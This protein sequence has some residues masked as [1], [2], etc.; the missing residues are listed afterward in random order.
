MGGPGTRALT[1][2]GPELGTQLLVGR[3]LP[4]MLLRAASLC[5][6]ICQPFWQ[7]KIMITTP[8]ACSPPSA[9]GSWVSCRGAWPGPCA[10]AAGGPRPEMA[11]SPQMCRAGSAC[12][13][14]E[15]R[16]AIEPAFMH[17][18]QELRFPH[19]KV[20]WGPTVPRACVGPGI[21]HNVIAAPGAVLLWEWQGPGQVLAGPG[22]HGVHRSD[23]GAL[24][25]QHRSLSWAFPCPQRGWAHCSNCLHSVHP[26]PQR[27]KASVKLALPKPVNLPSL[28]KVRGVPSVSALAAHGWERVA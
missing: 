20:Y 28:K 2:P 24:R 9:R 13:G 12:W 3:R 4:C 27:A 5:R 11:R 26:L 6:A 18:D 25:G 23:Q 1:Q 16:T 21:A 19:Q 17:P 10:R 15:I 22:R 7:C 8:E 14:A